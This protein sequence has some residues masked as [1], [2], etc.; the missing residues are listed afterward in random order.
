MRLRAM[1]VSL[2]RAKSMLWWSRT[3]KRL[4]RL[5][6]QFRPRVFNAKIVILAISAIVEDQAPGNG[7]PVG[8]PPPPGPAALGL[9][10]HTHTTHTYKTHSDTTHLHKTG[11]HAIHTTLTRH[12]QTHHTY[13]RQ[14]KRR[15]GRTN[16][17]NSD[18]NSCAKCNP[19]PVTVLVN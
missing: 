15:T 16:S 19:Q 11:T 1:W 13:T 8:R 2:R 5:V 7:D 14:D 4:A 10:A 17:H 3:F 9:H 12:T 18:A 6:G